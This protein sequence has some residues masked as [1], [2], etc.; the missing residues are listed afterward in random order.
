[1][2]TRRE[3]LQC[4]ALIG[5]AASLP[6]DLALGQENV[7]KKVDP[8]FSVG[9]RN[10]L[11]V[12]RKP[13]KIT[14]PDVGKFRVL[15]G[16]FHIHT[17]FS[18]G[19]VMPRDRV[20]EAVENGLDVISLT[21]HIEYRPF[22]GG[23]STQLNT[24]LKDRNDDHNFAFD[25]AKPEADKNNLILIRGTEITKNRMPPGHFNAIFL[26]DVNA[27]A[28]VVDDWKKMLAVAADQGAFVF[29]NHPGWVAPKSGGLEK[30]VPMSFTSEHD[31]VRRK[32]HL[33]GIEIFNGTSY[34]PIVA[35]WCNEMDMG[36]LSN[37]DIH[38]SEWNMYGNQN[39]LRPMTLILA[40]DRTEAAI[41]EA[42]FAHRTI[43][44]AAGMILGK[45]KLVEQLFNAC[46]E[47]KKSNNSIELTNLSD[48]PCKIQIANNSQELKPQNKLELTTNPTTK[49]LIVENWLIGT[50][51]P[52]EV[53]I[54]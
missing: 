4:A 38:K 17:L 31:E 20:S 48:I 42:F 9:N 35:D 45:P 32:G 2:S 44:W 34:Y 18:D 22:F 10:I 46:V 15:K 12:K 50:N 43:G 47:I 28:A 19:L 23:K 24:Q 37:S 54:G 30:G 25:L 53:A 29:W 1:M 51:K 52:L 5:A 26:K 36:L 21:E 41:R 14:I 16:D 3:F 27:V 8:L 33:H 13:R 7:T 40:T 6:V 39:P 11:N 49:K